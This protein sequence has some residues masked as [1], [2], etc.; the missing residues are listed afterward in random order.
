M[1]LRCC[2]YTDSGNAKKQQKEQPS[3]TMK[4]YIVFS[5]GQKL[6]IRGTICGEC[7][8]EFVLTFMSNFIV[9]MQVLSI[10]IKLY[11]RNH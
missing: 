9:S 7:N 6:E 2:F 10:W 3:G 11:V 8:G 1:L 4:N 5:N